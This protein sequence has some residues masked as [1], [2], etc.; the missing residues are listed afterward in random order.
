L[1][2]TKERKAK[3]GLEDE[4]WKGKIFAIYERNIV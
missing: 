1:G 4:K 2:N 3:D